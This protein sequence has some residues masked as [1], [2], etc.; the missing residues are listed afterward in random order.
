M[1]VPFHPVHDMPE[2]TSPSHPS[3]PTLK[4]N[5]RL[6][7]LQLN[8]VNFDLV[9]R[10]L[11]RHELPAFRRLLTAFQ[12]V[13]TFA[14]KKYDELE[15][16]I[17]WVSAH[18]GRTFREHGVF[19]LGDGAQ[20]NLPQVF[21]LLEQKGLSVGAVS[22]MNARNELRH[23]AY[24]IPDPWTATRSDE[25]GFSQRLTAMLQQTVNDNSQGRIS[26]KSLMAIGEAALRT[27]NPTRTA[28]LV[29][30]I[31]RSRGRQW[32][33][34][35]VLDQLIHMVHLYF[36]RSRKPDVSFVFMNAGAHIQHHYLFNSVFADATTRNPEWYVPTQADPILEM[37][38]TYDA[39]LQDYLAMCDA[40]DQLMVA[41][42]L[43]QVPYNRVK[44]YYR[45]KDHAR[46]LNALGIAHAQ[47]LP[48]MT[49]DF[50]VTFH[51]RADAEHA[52][53]VLSSVRLVRDGV[54]MF[55]TVEDRGLSLFVT[56]TYPTEIQESDSAVCES[57]EVTDVY[58]HVT[59]VAIKNGMHSTKGFAFLSPGT[60][61]SAPTQPVH[62]ACLFG[63][64]IEAAARLS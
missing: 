29:K 30:L 45:L 64:T 17:Q 56:L 19:R 12:R 63:L 15:P 42:G 8:E 25:S 50:E 27:L 44:F 52:A 43:T 38:V 9:E 21:E 49:R 60:V 37:L 34:A 55:G 51:T 40:G 61:D 57:G 26:K 48:R 3:K 58:R 22:P 47:V 20:C 31:L 32:V 11:C 54:A 7:V 36:L 59:F 14:E 10:Y 53:R 18:T 24:F 28:R 39:I 35:L 2:I 13:E 41:T 16:W 5:H 4:P 46:F 1:A 62:V 23:P 6:V 33:K